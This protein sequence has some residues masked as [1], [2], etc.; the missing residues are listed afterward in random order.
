MFQLKHGPPNCNPSVTGPAQDA[1]IPKRNDASATQTGT[2]K[3][4]IMRYLTAA[5]ATLTMVFYTT[6]VHATSLWERVLPHEKQYA[7]IARLFAK[8]SAKYF[9]T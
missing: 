4:I 2:P 1:A 7:E 9:G 3:E 5:T 8:L 6:A